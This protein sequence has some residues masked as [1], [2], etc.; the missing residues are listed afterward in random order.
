M[1]VYKV[2]FIL[3]KIEKKAEEE[4]FNRSNQFKLLKNKKY[5][6]SAKSKLYKKP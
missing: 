2:I 5:K 4:L 6:K 1:N 3:N